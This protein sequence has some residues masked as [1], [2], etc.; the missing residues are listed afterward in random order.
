[1]PRK[2]LRNKPRDVPGTLELT[3][4]GN[5]R[6]LKILVT[7]ALMILAAGITL[8]GFG[9]RS[10]LSTLHKVEL[11]QV[12]HSG[13][14]ITLKEDV[15]EV[16]VEVR[17]FRKEFAIHKTKVER[18]MAVEMVADGGQGDEIVDGGGE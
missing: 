10:T 3:S 11:K 7:V 13:R 6:V 2:A 15:A 14:M 16:K 8:V 17:D 1:M 4:N 12:E 18:H 5:G 9:V